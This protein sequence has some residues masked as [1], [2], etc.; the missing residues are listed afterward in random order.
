MELAKNLNLHIDFVGYIEDLSF[1]YEKAKI[2]C[3]CSKQEG[4]P[5]VLIEAAFYECA[6]Q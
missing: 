5:I 6:N 4:L 1:Y 2:L 3:L